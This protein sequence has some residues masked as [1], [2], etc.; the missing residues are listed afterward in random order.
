MDSSVIQGMARWPN[1][2]ACFDW[3]EL[4]RRGQWRLGPQAPRQAVNHTGL[5]E[6]IGR[7]YEH[8]ASGRWFM[9]NGPQRV[10]AVLEYTP[11]VYRLDAAGQLLSHTGV[12]TEPLGAWLDD[13]G[14]LLLES[15]L[16]IGVL[17]DRDL[18]ALLPLF[19]SE[20]GHALTDAE[21][22]AFICAGNPSLGALRWHDKLVP[23]G[24]ISQQQ[25]ATTFGFQPRPSANC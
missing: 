9:Q 22:E 21:L 11:W 15:P 12:K 2:P 23:L 14:N 1:V 16:G 18:P 24:C 6:F 7:N 5:S 17:D 4:D 19:C 13:Q 10:Y 20:S 3:L 8:D 25:V